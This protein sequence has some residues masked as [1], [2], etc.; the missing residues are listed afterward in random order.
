M[1]EQLIIR[2]DAYTQI[3]TGHLMRCLALSQNWIGKGRAVTMITCCTSESLRKRLLAEG[4]QVIMMEK[5]HPNPLDWEI[6]FQVLRKHSAAWVVLDGYN[7]DS[8]YQNRIKKAGHRLLVIDDTAHLDRY[9][10]DILL[11]Q[12]LYAEKLRYFCET[13][14]RTLF[15]NL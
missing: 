13:P 9:Y 12:N 4:I 7:F 14:A 1:A 6:T 15:G 3:G 10:A 8:E 11:N 2:A 5:P